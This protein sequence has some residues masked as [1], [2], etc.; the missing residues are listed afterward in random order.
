M[1]SPDELNA[2]LNHVTVAPLT[3]NVRSLR[4][5]VTAT[6]AGRTSSVVLD[7]LRAVDVKRLR[8]RIGK[9]DQRTMGTILAT[10]Q[11]MFWP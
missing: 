2:H 9:V 1:V 6:F 8:G 4:F 10:L 5:R 11:A 7:Q 3:R